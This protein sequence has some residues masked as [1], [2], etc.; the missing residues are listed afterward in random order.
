MTITFPAPSAVRIAPSSQ[1][2]HLLEPAFISS[3]NFGTRLFRS[4]IIRSIAGPGIDSRY[5]EIGRYIPENGLWSI[6]NSTGTINALAK[7]I[8]ALALG[9]E[10]EVIIDQIKGLGEGGYYL[11]MDCLNDG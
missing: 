6:R 11:A 5:G 2:W 4:S 10:L 7:A 8:S 3:R 1:L 9:I